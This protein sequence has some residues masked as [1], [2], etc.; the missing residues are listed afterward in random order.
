MSCTGSCFSVPISQPNFKYYLNQ[1][2]IMKLFH[3]SHLNLLLLLSM[4]LFAGCSDSENKD[5][6][7]FSGMFGSDSLLSHNPD[8]NET[9]HE[10]TNSHHTVDGKD[11]DTNSTSNMGTGESVDNNTAT[12]SNV[13]L[14]SLSLAIEK[15]S[16]NL[17]E[18]TTLKVV[19]TYEDNKSK[20]VTE[21]IEWIITPKDAI[22]IANTTLTVL[23]D[24]GTTIQA[25]LGSV[26]SDPVNLSIYW[27]VN[28]HKLPPEPDPTVNN[29]TLLGVDV[30]GNGV[31]DDAER[32]IYQRFSRDPDYPKTKVAIAMQYAKA[33]Q[34]IIA[35]DPKNAFDNK[36]YKKMDYALDCK[37]YWYDNATKKLNLSSL[38]GS[39]A[40]TKFRLQNKIYDN[41]FRKKLFNTKLRMKAYFYYN[42]SL[43]GHILGGGGGVL[44]STKDKCD[45]DIDSFGEL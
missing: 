12:T 5:N 18:N 44:S 34:F 14:L 36:S 28:G 16:L 37:W 39:I 11:N 43:S 31:R 21:Q 6:G 23:K 10:E 24:T 30:N 17:D 45:F 25:K 33:Y 40:G 3:S 29:A 19:A 4:L 15:T 13:K 26:T 35:N 32:Y 41:K 38:E 1:G 27:E 2:I 42:S 20:D 22:K 7:F 8:K 9:A